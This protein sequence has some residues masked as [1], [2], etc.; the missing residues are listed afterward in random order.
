MTIPYAACFA[1][2]RK[3]KASR[4]NVWSEVKNPLLQ[5]L[6]YFLSVRAF[7][8]NRKYSFGYEQSYIFTTCHKQNTPILDHNTPLKSRSVADSVCELVH[9]QQRGIREKKIPSRWNSKF[10]I[11][12]ESITQCK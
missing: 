3:T 1:V 4:F 2:G 10:F 7:Q 5:F 11:T 8:P 12:I 9:F 6:S